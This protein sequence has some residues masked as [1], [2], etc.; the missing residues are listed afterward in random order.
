MPF[1]FSYFCDLLE[2]LEDYTTRD[3]PPLNAQLDSLSYK[4]IEQWFKSHRARID[5]LDTSHAALLSAFF[6]ERRS[7]RVYGMRETNL[8]RL[9]GR[10]LGLGV[11]RRKL[12]EKCATAGN[13]DLGAR[14]ELVQRQAE[15][16]IPSPTN[17]VTVEEIDRALAGLASRSRFSAPEVPNRR[18]EF[19]HDPQSILTPIYHRLQSRDAKWLTRMIL[20]SYMPVVFP[21]QTVLRQY[22][23]LLL[24]ILKFQSNFDAAAACLRGPAIG[25]FPAHPNRKSEE[26]RLREIAEKE[27]IPKVGIKVGRVNFLKARSIK[28]CLQ[29]TEARHMSLERKYDGEYCQIHIDVSKGPNWLR[30]FSKSGKDST[31]DR[32]GISTTLRKCLRIGQPGCKI[33]ARCILEGEMVVFSDKDN[34]ILPFYKLRK[35]LSRSGVFLNAAEDSPTYDHEHLMIIFFDLLLLDNQ[36]VLTKNYN[37]RIKVLGDLVAQEPGRAELASRQFIDFCLVEAPSQLKEAFAKGITARWEGFILKPIDQPYFTLGDVSPSR[38]GGWIKLKKDYIRGLGDTADFA[39][40]GAGFDVRSAREL[41][42]KGLRWTHFHIGCLL[43]KDDVVRF[44]HKPHL[45]VIEAFDK[46]ISPRDRTALNQHGQFQCEPYDPENDRIKYDIRMEQGLSCKMDVMFREPFVLEMMGGGFDRPANKAYY[47]LRWPRVLK[48]QWDRSFKDTVSFVE[49]QQMAQESREAPVDGASEDEKEWVSK[50]EQADP[51]KSSRARAPK[52]DRSFEQASSRGTQETSSQSSKSSRRSQRTRVPTI[53]R[54]DTA[55]L[56]S[57]TRS[58]VSKAVSQAPTRTS[59][60]K[61]NSLLTP[62]ASS[63]VT[64]VKESMTV[65]LRASALEGENA[66]ISRKRK[67][68]ISEGQKRDGPPYKRINVQTSIKAQMFSTSST[69]SMSNPAKSSNAGPLA[70]ISNTPFRRT[71]SSMHPSQPSRSRGIERAGAIILWR[72]AESLR[73]V[74]IPGKEA[75]SV[76]DGSGTP[77]TANFSF[78]LTCCA[79]T[80]PSTAHPHTHFK[81]PSSSSSSGSGDK[82]ACPLRDTIALL[83]PCIALMPYLTS[84]LLPRHGLPYLLSPRELLTSHVPVSTNR[85]VL[86]ETHRKGPTAA[87]LKRVRALKAARVTRATSTDEG[88]PRDEIPVIIKVYDWRLLE[89]VDKVERGGR[90]DFDYFERCFVCDL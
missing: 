24:E 85:I 49:L 58:S 26:K 18:K 54:V 88:E 3:P 19:Q 9:L 45:R 83:T 25:K 36:A 42:I 61:T 51:K 28:H 35:H 29:M 7:D 17:E 70:E 68:Q 33:S 74:D 23:F 53:I 6:P 11:S 2:K 50:L 69:E 59:S 37:D 46:T 56:Q 4:A 31:Q 47:T 82:T 87:I 77:T 67:S 57:R 5:A 32:R 60:S 66:T 41:D 38:S 72:T 43:N 65:G 52:D 14:V 44:G 21:E 12:L 48:I 13:G 10:V 78:T 20:K 64:E 30:I 90:V 34:K 79:N 84:D 1:R 40:V 22:H 63:P 76:V 89:C 73:P 39:I 71:G 80:P 15:M 55:E 8:V 27:L 75:S 86:V 16:P 81:Q 62:P